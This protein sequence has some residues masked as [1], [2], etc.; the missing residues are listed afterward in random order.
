MTIGLRSD[1]SGTYGAMTLFGTDRVI[2]DTSGNVGIG[3]APSSKLHV[4]GHMM[5]NDSSYATYSVNNTAGTSWKGGYQFKSNGTVKYEIVTDISASGSNSLSFYD[6][7]AATT[8]LQIG[9]SG[10]LGI[11]GG[12]TYGTAGYVLTS[13]GPSAAPSW[14]APTSTGKLLVQ[15]VNFTT[16]A[17][18]SASTTIPGDNT[19]PQITEGTEYMT[20]AITPNNASNILV[21]EVDFYGSPAGGLWAIAAL[22]QDS[23]AN[24]LSAGI[25][26][27][28]GASPVGLIRMRYVMSAGTTSSTTF[29][30][31][32]GTQ[33]GAALTFNG[34]S[35]TQLFGGA[36]ASGI[37]IR[38]Y[39]A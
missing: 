14:S 34:Q 36:M 3:I 13:G 28:A 7:S 1:A 2:I 18:A 4:N 8:R 21:I 17:V 26:Y 9:P 30:V 16:G 32:A 38:E 27:P 31:R 35:G 22:F 37:T 23:T 33:S 29:R 6:T 39:T 5:A 12:A 19:I 24:A 10:Q 15:Q 11:G 20:L 25:F